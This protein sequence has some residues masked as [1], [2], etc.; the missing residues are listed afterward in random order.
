MA[1][2]LPNNP[3]AG[4]AEPYWFEWVTGLSYLIELMDEDSDVGEV[5]F[6][7]C[8]TKGWD[9]F[10]IRYRNGR[11]Q[12]LQMKHSRT[13]DPITFSDLIAVESSNSRSLIRSLSNAWK[14]ERRRWKRI[15]CQLV[16]NRPPGM[17]WH[18]DRPPLQS[19][20]DALR[21][22]VENSSLFADIEWNN[23]DQQYRPAWQEFAGELSDLTPDER[24][25]F[26]K[27]FRIKVNAPDSRQLEENIRIRLGVL[28]GLPRSSVEPLFNALISNLRKW[29]CDTRRETPWINRAELRTILES[30]DFEPAWRGR[31]EV[32]SPEQVF[33]S[34]NAT[35]D[36]IRS[37]LALAD[38]HRVDFLAAE[39][40][41]GK[42]TCISRI[43]RQ[44]SLFWKDKCI[45]IRF[46]TYRP[47]RPG[48]QNIPVDIDEG[49][50]PDSLWLSLL[51]QIRDNLRQTESISQL[52]VPVWLHGMKWE[53]ARAHVLRIA[54]AIGESWGRT[55]VI[56]ID[57]I[58][59]AARA[60]RKNLPEFLRT[61][62]APDDVPPHVRLLLAGQ[63]PD[64][65]PE[66]PVFLRRPHA[67]VK[68][69]PLGPL[70]DQDVEVLWKSTN[71]SLTR[72]NAI[73]VR[74]LA[75]KA[76]YQTLPTVFAVEATRYCNTLNEVVAA[77][78]ALPLADSLQRYYDDIWRSAIGSDSN[79][80]RL[81]A[82]FAFLRERPTGAIFARA[83]PGCGK[84]DSDWTDILRK[85]RPLVRETD[86]GFELVHNDIRV[87]LDALLE[88]EPFLRRD[89]ASALANYY[90]DPTSN[91]YAAHISLANL[92]TTANRRAD[93]ADDFTVE[94]VI[95][96]SALGINNEQLAVECNLA[97]DAALKRRN[98][99]L[100]HSVACAALTL[101]QLLKTATACADSPSL[102]KSTALPAFLPVEGEAPAIELWTAR[103][104]TKLLEGCKTLIDGGALARARIVLRQWIGETPLNQL[105]GQLERIKAENDPATRDN[106]TVVREIQQLGYLCAICNWPLNWKSRSNTISPEHIW[107]FEHGWVLGLARIQNRRL[108]LRL[109]V[110]STPRARVAWIFA[111][112]EAGGYKRWGEVR[113]LLKRIKVGAMEIEAADRIIMGW[114]A[115]RAGA[116]SIDFWRQPLSLSKY[117]L[118]L[119]HVP[120]ET[121]QVL[122]QWITYDDVTRE[123][124]QVA[125]DL[126]P[127]LDA[128]NFRPTHQA[129]VRQILRA[130][131]VAG[132]ILRYLDRREPESAKIMVPP[133]ILEG[134]LSNLWCKSADLFSL[135][136]DVRDA[137]HEAGAMLAEIADECGD[138]Y[139]HIL[140]RIAR[141]NF[142][143]VIFHDHGRQLFDMLRKWSDIEFLEN[144]VI[145]ASTELIDAIHIHDTGSRG[146]N[147]ANLAHF[148][149]EL[150]LSDIVSRLENRFR[151]TP[152]GYS[153]HKEWVFEPLLRWFQI[154]RHESPSVWKNYGIQL[155]QL[156]GI[157]DSQHGD[158]TVSNE[159]TSEIG[160]AA[161]ICGPGDLGML[162][163]FLT[164]RQSRHVLFDLR[165]TVRGGLKVALCE[166]RGL[167]DVS[168]LPL[169]ALSIALGR[170]P[171]ESARDTVESL[172]GTDEVAS[173]ISNL[174]EWKRGICIAHDIQGISS[175]NHKVKSRGKPSTESIQVVKSEVLFKEMIEG[176]SSG[177]ELLEK[178]AQLVELLKA[179][180]SHERDEF[181]SRVLSM[182]ESA[183]GHLWSIDYNRSKTIGRIYDNLSENERWRFMGG[184][185]S[186]GWVRGK[187]FDGSDWPYMVI[188]SVIDSF[189]RARA[190]K[191]GEQFGEAAF[192][193]VLGTHWR[194][195]SV[196][197]E[198]NSLSLAQVGRTWTEMVLDILF[199]LAQTDGCESLYMVISALRFFGEAHPEKIA[200]ICLQ[201]LRDDRVRPAIFA[202]AEIWAVRNPASLRECIGE[203][204]EYES[205][206]TLIERLDAWVIG[207]LYS[208]ASGGLPRNFVL[209]EDSKTS[210]LALPRGQR[211]FDSGG[212]YNGLMH[213]VSS[214]GAI[215]GR[216]D[217][218]TRCLGSMDLA[219]WHA[220][221]LTSLQEMADVEVHTSPSVKLAWDC[222]TL[223]SFT[224]GND[225]LGKAVCFQ[226][227]GESW[228][229]D[230]ASSIRQMLGEGM[231]GWIASS[232]PNRWI[233]NLSWPSHTDIEQWYGR[234]AHWTDVVGVQVTSLLQGQDICPEYVVLGATLNLPTFLR[235]VECE[236]WLAA[237]NQR[238]LLGDQ[239]KSTAPS[240]R[241]FAGLI[242]NW[243]FC[244][245]D[246][247]TS[248]VRFARPFVKYPNSE[249]T[250]I[251][252]ENWSKL[253]N[254]RCSPTSPLKFCLPDGKVVAWYER[255]LDPERASYKVWRQPILN[256]WVALRS[257]FP[258]EYDGLKGWLPKLFKESRK[259]LRPE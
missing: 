110:T 138:V 220:K 114:Y 16:T 85:L 11:T 26:L 190:I 135:P 247:E 239:D 206:G 214:N 44:G 92:L 219:S 116:A 12:L 119:A 111:V 33:P 5:A 166:G 169:L 53:I 2:T 157:C 40:G 231:D 209:P 45:S 147:V 256:R 183:D 248:T 198:E 50:H 109:W 66:Y 76:K 151:R 241:S 200:V 117:G 237:P 204:E 32:E 255:W 88:N 59:H 159:I 215:N 178:M 108:A 193:Q 106:E 29:T 78:E 243:G 27:T 153:S 167:N 253:W 228:A 142:A 64:A 192:R 80:S 194:W 222:R 257:G 74:L 99:L 23:D 82:A 213:V 87:H 207:A 3:T 217:R 95:E 54:N 181:V 104:F 125:E 81:A 36:A 127:L 113:A 173:E 133:A 132:R 90:R 154:L 93:F 21:V 150:G 107:T 240:G 49:V 42:T 165:Q 185:L 205:V 140:R 97:L 68:C 34:R 129:C 203:F 67:S 65:Y 180:G 245:G 212:E 170:W 179:E 52:R 233:G 126:L 136:I 199:L 51:W 145:E 249:L 202:L 69:H 9:D 196:S 130:Y 6:Q 120:L 89:T 182:L 148:A 226:C 234:G 91:R 100:L 55:F 4:S 79:N 124:A 171:E 101:H 238:G 1:N 38:S 175:K 57:G 162:V 17:K 70:S 112:S 156:D 168:T 43:A 18:R 224:Q 158:N 139:R 30:D 211:L 208:I 144:A 149:R 221:Q 235:D 258:Q 14:A 137:R 216:I 62:P 8:G 172:L 28:T 197:Q 191:H 58:D 84:T 246:L 186:N 210:T 73:A 10:G 7:L 163:E 25:A 242:S 35:I 103:D 20:L 63:P 123:F 143:S 244:G 250:V 184:V 24:L 75:E 60:Q 115:A 83:F 218:L 229:P 195:H 134:V 160:A 155:L 22:R 189:C 187:T 39:P 225:I 174:P 128:N 141:F 188:F 122:A 71:P 201:G 56:C 37:S 223:R 146:E 48:D 96:A 46:Y 47:L 152:I 19:F 41:S 102:L 177:Y 98:W 251:P 227:S 118:S 254:W 72:D 13:S 252:T 77:L 31:C 105:L 94:W 232:C 164:Q 121:L 176:G 15:D 86:A 259:L 61:L 131:A 236:F 161:I 230:K